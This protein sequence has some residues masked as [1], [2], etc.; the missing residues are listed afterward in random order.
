MNVVD[1][2]MALKEKTKEVSKSKDR[3]MVHFRVEIMP[4]STLLAE[5]VDEAEMTRTMRNL[6]Q[7]PRGATLEIDVRKAVQKAF[8]GFSFNISAMSFYVDITV[9]RD[10][11]SKAL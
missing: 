4:Q 1:L 6:F 9:K 8:E 11:E 3:N 7:A 2:T 10:D 5:S